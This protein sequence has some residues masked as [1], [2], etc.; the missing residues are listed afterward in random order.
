MAT[1][2]KDP[3]AEE[4]DDDEPDDEPEEPEEK[5]L[6]A[7]IEEV[8]DRV[9]PKFLKKAGTTKAAPAAKR[10]TYRD[11]EDRMNDL[12]TEKVKELLGK[13]KAQG[14]E[15]PEPGKQTAAPEPVPAAPRRRRVESIMGW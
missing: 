12:V 11:D 1:D 2:P 13:E 7:K 8:L 5:D 10:P 9:I 15:H 14:E 4:A 3:P 6:E